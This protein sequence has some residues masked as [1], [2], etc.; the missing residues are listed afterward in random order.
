MKYPHGT[1]RITGVLVPVAAL[2][3]TESSGC[4]EFADLPLLADWCAATG[5]KLIQILPVNDTGVYGTWWDSYPYSSLSVHAIDAVTAAA[6]AA[7]RGEI[8]LAR[9]AARGN[10]CVT[11][12]S[13]T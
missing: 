13:R 5:Q 4:G 1:A 10:P 12:T 11:V 9:T 2:R 8:A 3:S 6:I 7:A